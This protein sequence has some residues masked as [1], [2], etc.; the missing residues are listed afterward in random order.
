[1][2]SDSVSIVDVAAN[3]SYQAALTKRIELST[4]ETTKQRL[5]TLKADA[6]STA[7][8][9]RRPSVSTRFAH[10]SKRCAVNLACSSVSKNN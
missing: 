2:P 4:D 1:M 5:T 3:T 10:E 9:A 8:V 7:T 6:A